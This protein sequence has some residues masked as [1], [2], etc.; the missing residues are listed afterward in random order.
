MP[1]TRA[2][3]KDVPFEKAMNAIESFL[4]MIPV[5]PVDKD[6]LTWQPDMRVVGSFLDAY[7][8]TGI[9]MPV[10]EKFRYK[11]KFFPC[12]APVRDTFINDLGIDIDN[13]IGNMLWGNGRVGKNGSLYLFAKHHIEMGYLEYGQNTVFERNAYGEWKK[14]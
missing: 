3:F 1:S 8:Y 6:E 10:F 11:F 12:I 14:K 4:V 2:T 9:D 5:D 13:L 7:G